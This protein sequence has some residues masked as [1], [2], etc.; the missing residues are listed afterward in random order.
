MRYALYIVTAFLLIDG[1]IK[2]LSEN[3]DVRS[4]GYV[5]MM[6]SFA[7]FIACVVAWVNNSE[8]K[9]SKAHQS[10]SKSPKSN[11]APPIP[12]KQKNN[13]LPVENAAFRLREIATKFDD[14]RFDNFFS[15]QPIGVTRSTN[16][17]STS[18]PGALN[19][20]RGSI[21]VEYINSRSQ[22]REV[23]RVEKTWSNVLGAAPNRFEIYL[24]DATLE[25]SPQTM[26][27]HLVL[28]AFWQLF[29]NQFVPLPSEI[30]KP[31]K[32]TL[33]SKLRIVAQHLDENKQTI[34]AT[35]GALDV[36]KIDFSNVQKP[37]P[38]TVTLSPP[39][40]GQKIQG[41]ILDRK[42]GE[43]AYGVVYEAT[44]IKDQGIKAA[45]KFMKIPE[46]LATKVKPGSPTYHRLAERHLAEAKTSLNFANRAYVVSARDYGMEPW[47][48]IIYP[49]STVG[50]VQSLID[51]GKMSEAVWWDFAHDLISGLMS[52]HDEGIVHLDIKPDNI[53]RFSDR[54]A[55]LDLGLAYTKDY[56]PD[57]VGGTPGFFAPEVKATF[58]TKGNNSKLGFEADIYS[59]GVT[60]LWAALPAEFK[61]LL[62]HED[63]QDT[64]SLLD[65]ANASPDAKS[66]ISRMIDQNPKKRGSANELLF[67]VS[68]HVNLEEKISQIEFASRVYDQDAAEN[69]EG[70]EYAKLNETFDGPL[71]SWGVIE[72]ELKVLLEKVR[73]AFFAFNLQFDDES[74]DMYFQAIYVGDGWVLECQ[75]DQFGE[76]NLTPQQVKK[77]LQLGWSAPT[78]S[79]PNYEKM[80]DGSDPI[81]MGVEFTTA[82]EQSYGI[83]PAEIK[84]ISISAQNKNAY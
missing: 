38:K 76:V 64:V 65:F 48:W 12:S 45:F 82:L 77:L 4:Q 53:M 78:D 54:F 66:L 80:V 5:E 1:D 74:R 9:K 17:R 39:K 35:N 75:S 60:L 70:G 72:R 81:A 2:G 83:R 41:Y 55:I 3:A 84:S 42:L 6:I 79:S 20:S 28:T 10:A 25:F 47:P 43:G 26:E 13:F 19:I 22:N 67:L 24:K 50:S 44:N 23:K 16:S 58:E 57:V 71:T 7:L 69:L 36:D 21:M 68:D 59:A 32:S 14:S 31:E 62:I 33:G 37:K 56:Q 51:S 46:K 73:P 29:S 11:L 8:K 18:G 27:D 15:I 52:I 49:L 34:T 63:P 40:I 61:V 30:G